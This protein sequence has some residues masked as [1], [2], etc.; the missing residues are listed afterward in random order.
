CLDIA[1]LGGGCDVF[2]EDS[3]YNVHVPKGQIFDMPNGSQIKGDPVSAG[4]PTGGTDLTFVGIRPYSSP[5]CDPFS[6]NNCPADGIPVFS[7]IF[8]ENTFAN[9]SYNS[10]QAN[11][12]KR[13]SN[14]L[15]FQA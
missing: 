13:F 15:Q 6:G 9:S 7:N 10:L 12:E 3:A 2:G 11:L 14:G 1:N 8:Q 4:N 5:N